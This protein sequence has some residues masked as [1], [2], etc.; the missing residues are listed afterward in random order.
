[1]G[2]RILLAIVLA[3]VV[4]SCERKAEGQ[5]VAVVNNEEITAADLNAELANENL[6]PSATTKE[7]RALALQK[8]I[9][10]RLL[11]QQAKTDGLDKTPE[12]INQQRRANEDLLINSLLSRQVKTAQVPSP[13]EISRFEASRPEMFA[14]REVWTLEQILYPLPKN[15]ALVTKLGA[16]KTLDEIA[17]LLTAS[18][19]QFQRGTRRIDSAIFPHAAY[20]QIANLKPGEPFIFPGQDKAV[21]NV[22][23][24]RQPANVT[25]EQARQLAVNAIR[26]QQVDKF[27][28]DRV[29]SLKA[30]A[31]IQYQPGFA[32]PKS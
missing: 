25:P 11:A 30:S 23:T 32:P 4:S 28:Q 16:A 3:F 19:I 10:R 21:A 1:M 27:V 8:L 20:A 24:A 17:Q 7:T 12:F 18:G 5:T 29:K 31:K 6:S 22:I 2:Q 26:R 14:N 9:D 15:Q 13:D